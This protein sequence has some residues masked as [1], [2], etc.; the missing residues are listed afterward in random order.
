[1]KMCSSD[2]AVV[3]SRRIGDW[4]VKAQDTLIDLANWLIGCPEKPIFASQRSTTWCRQHFPGPV[5]N[6]FG[7]TQSATLHNPPS[8]MVQC[9]QCHR[10]RQKPLAPKLSLKFTTP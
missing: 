8:W 10:S 3:F 9:C 4:R 6:L 2:G 5:G 7:M 1:M